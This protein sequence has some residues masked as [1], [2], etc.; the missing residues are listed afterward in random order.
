MMDI[1][2]ELQNKRF[3][4][5]KPFE[6][7]FTRWQR[8]MFRL[9]IALIW[10]ALVIEIISAVGK[11]TDR[12]ESYGFIGYTLHCVMVPLLINVGIYFIG[13]CMYR[14]P[15]ITDEEKVAV[16][17]LTMIAMFT[18]LVSIHYMF[19]V[20]LGMFVIPVFISTIYANRNVVI[21]TFAFCCLGIAI[22]TGLTVINHRDAIKNEYF[23]SLFI[24]AAIMTFV[25]VVAMF[26]VENE[27]AKV[28]T[29]KRNMRSAARLKLEASHDS[30]TGLYNRKA[31]LDILKS[32]MTVFDP[33]SDNTLL[34]SVI[35]IDHFK[36]I[37]DTYGHS[38]GDIVL[39]KLGDMFRVMN[40]GNTVVGRYGG[41]EFL[42]VFT[43]ITVEEA[44]RRVNGLRERFSDY[45]FEE[46][47][48]RR[49]TISA[50]IAAYSGG[51][52][53][54]E[55]FDEADHAMY[56]AKTLGRN[57]VERAR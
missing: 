36:Q 49:V 20:L 12:L 43:N 18:S 14:H 9:N 53:L 2:D 55:F 52:N 10:I 25:F 44:Y 13:I 38:V 16:P 28:E 8:N 37:N 1:R 57:R 30:L 22:S 3:Q 29:I 15:S 48:G 4:L 11:M 27:R 54:I 50:G 6:N 19:P 42:V 33:Q 51:K 26:T 39:R 23:A 7:L 31:I 56:K 35:D 47:D 46:L 5:V 32:Y 40:S 34:I 41:E 45:N 21:R 24:I 17:I